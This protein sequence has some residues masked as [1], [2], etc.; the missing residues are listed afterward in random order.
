MLTSFGTKLG[1]VGWARFISRRQMKKLTRKKKAILKF[2][3]YEIN[4]FNETVQKNLT[5]DINGSKTESKS[6]RHRL[7]NDRP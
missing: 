2:K 5:G 4:T 6:S 1:L 3:G 7:P